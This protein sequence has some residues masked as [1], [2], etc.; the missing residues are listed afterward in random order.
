MEKLVNKFLIE[1]INKGDN[2][3]EFLNKNNKN[4]ILDY[5]LDKGNLY[6]KG[7][8]RYFKEATDGK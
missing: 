5:M 3:I 8:A 7:I 4:K 6:V 1:Y 2:A